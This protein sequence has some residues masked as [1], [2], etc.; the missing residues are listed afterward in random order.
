MINI[1]KE[2]S[3]LSSTV[4]R[5]YSLAEINDDKQ[6]RATIDE[7]S[8]LSV[9]AVCIKAFGSFGFLENSHFEGNVFI[10]KSA[11]AGQ[12]LIEGQIW[13]IAVGALYNKKSAK[14]CYSAMSGHLKD[15]SG[16]SIPKAEANAKK[17]DSPDHQPI[18]RDGHLSIYID[19]TWPGA[20]NKSL[21]MIGVIGGIAVPWKGIDEDRLP[22]IKTHLGNG[23]EA[24]E[25]I[26]RLLSTANV[27]PFVLPMK[28]DKPVGTG[29]PLYFELVQHTIMIL[30]GWLLPRREAPTSIDIFLEHIAGFGD[31]HNET[32][33][34]KTL[35]QAMRLI[36]GERRFVN[37]SI[38]SVTWVDK[39]FG[40]VPYGDL[41]CKTCVPLPEQQKLANSVGVWNWEGF[42]PFTKDAFPI[43][44]DMDTASP[45][46]F[47]DLLMAFAKHTHGTPF[48]RHVRDA[49]VKRAQN[50]IAF[51][52]AL[53]TK[54]ED[55]YCEQDRDMNLL[56]RI[57][58]PFLEA[59]PVNAFEGK[60]RMQLLRFL[61]GFQH[62]NHNG[63]PDLANALI[64][65]YHSTRSRMMAFDRDLCAYADLV[66]AVHY[67]D[68][69]SFGDALRIINGWIEDSLFPALSVS[70]RGRMLSSRGQSLALLGQHLEA[71]EAFTKAL[72][73]FSSE[74][75]LL[76]KDIGQTM[77][78][79]AMNL[80]DSVMCSAKP[81]IES[82]M[83]RSLLEAAKDFTSILDQP[84]VA[85]LFLKALWKMR[86]EQATEVRVFLKNL[87]QDIMVQ[88]QH[89]G[90]L[91]LFYVA[92]LTK[93]TSPLYAQARAKDVERIFSKIGNG[94]TLGLI[95]A[96]VCAMFKRQGLVTV[97]ERNF[98]SNL[99]VV[100]KQIPNAS[101]IIDVLRSGWE[102]ESI[103]IEGILP[104]NYC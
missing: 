103:P 46:G 22:A 72:V 67:H 17:G 91:I 9:E 93:D 74:S 18:S 25:A 19:E 29:G 2:S 49:A 84:Y 23:R 60:P 52:D 34:I 41:V 75:E 45:A 100:A 12:P 70:N 30:L 99:D 5:Q 50:E 73:H 82:L 96:Y 102:D 1:Q 63:K 56:N 65:Q 55:D 89:P 20:Q 7:L 28:F 88:E 14:W 64:G 61:V 24:L 21:E 80:L 77:T 79:R 51:R 71:D 69:F 16:T 95:H 26:Q 85:H 62:A 38:H 32:E 4:T 40:Y 33:F 87:P 104:F 81:L 86:Q 27:F 13:I 59:F 42:L 98:K 76:K 31:D 66:L 94:E 37:L 90:E 15:S 36:S 6:R 48:F 10:H 8:N 47:A 101:S 57:I 11:T 58:P 39:N 54:F 43:L 83:R 3:V 68:T 35:M 97:S 44:R 78:Y 53:F 92:L